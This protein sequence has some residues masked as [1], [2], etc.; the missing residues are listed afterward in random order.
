M[1][2]PQRQQLANT[3]SD[4]DLRYA[5]VD[6]RKRKRMI[7]NR[8]S[9]RMSRVKKQQH[10]DELLGEINQLQN[11]NNKNMEASLPNSVFWLWTF[12]RFL[13]CCWNHGSFLAQFSPSHHQST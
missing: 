13:I 5:N 12:L 11:D 9:P 1:A 8:E 4:G 10:L 2:S 6:E 7:S 3:W